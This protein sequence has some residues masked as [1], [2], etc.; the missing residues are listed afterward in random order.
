M[1]VRFVTAAVLASALAVA[2]ADVET[3]ARAPHGQKPA[4]APAEQPPKPPKLWPPDAAALAKRRLNAE[5]LPLF[6]SFEPV[7]ITITADFK[8]VQR[9]RDVDSKTLYPGTLAIVTAG[10]AGPPIPIQLRTRG[11]VRR[12]TRVCE[13][14]PLRLEFPKAAVKGTVF[15]GLDFVRLGTHCQSE[16]IYQQYTLKEYLANRLLLTLTPRA[17]RARLARVTYADTDAG[18]QP[19]TRLGIFF[20]DADD[21]AKRMEAREL[22]VPRQVFSAVDQPSLLFMSL[23][24]YMI[25]NTDYSIFSLHNVIMIDDAKGVRYVAPYDF[26]YSG[27]VYAHYATPAKG[28]GL[29]SVRDRMYRGPC[30][31]VAE[32]EQALQPF[33]DKQ[34]ELLAL[35]ASLPDFDDGHRRN[36]E[37]FLNEFFEL[38]GRPDRIKKVFVTDCKPLDGM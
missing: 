11:H 21:M 2:V 26:D 37:K 32:V 18:K 15:A 23:F 19:Y 31:T 25:G 34:A 3:A 28:L 9:D 22:P 33:R 13:F 29:A 14:A 4:A 16:R 6:S 38:T 36:A 27:L 17:L 1:L 12:S 8:T 30:K 5:A 24:Q 35:P 20:E 10:A 7:E